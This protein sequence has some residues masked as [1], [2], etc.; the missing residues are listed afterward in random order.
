MRVVGSLRVYWS[1]ITVFLSAAVGGGSSIIVWQPRPVQFI[2]GAGEYRTR[3]GNDAPGL[4][5]TLRACHDRIESYIPNCAIG[6]AIH[7]HRFSTSRHAGA[8]YWPIT[9]GPPKT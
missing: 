1:K 4:A 8:I 9:L 3:R 7:Q 6:R 2:G 5:T